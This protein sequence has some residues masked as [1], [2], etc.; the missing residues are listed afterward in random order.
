MVEI[1]VL[2]DG[3]SLVIPTMIFVSGIAVYSVAM[4]LNIMF[5]R[6]EIRHMRIEAERRQRLDL[7]EKAENARKRRQKNRKVIKK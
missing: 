5:E 7:I 4:S 1:H 6:M 3:A 2:F